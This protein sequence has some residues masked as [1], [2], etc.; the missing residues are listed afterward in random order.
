MIET[1]EPSETQRAVAEKFECTE[2]T[3]RYVLYCVLFREGSYYDD[4]LFEPTREYRN[5]LVTVEWDEG[6]EDRQTAR[7]VCSRSISVDPEKI[8]P[9]N[10]LTEE[11]EERA[12]DTG[13]CSNCRS[14][15]V[16]K[17]DEC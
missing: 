8:V 2:A 12:F 1:R 9:L 17:L 16:K 10:E 13:F 5:H 15:F 6:S 7:A 3:T 11:Q 14:R 4:R